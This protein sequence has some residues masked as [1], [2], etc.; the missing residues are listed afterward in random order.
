MERVHYRR[1][2]P[3]VESAPFLQEEEPGAL[4]ETLILQGIISGVM[5]VV[6]ML[7]SVIN[8]AFLSPAQEAI[9]ETL[10]GATNLRELYEATR[11]FGAETLG[12]SWLE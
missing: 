2:R 4:G 1:V 12:L 11:Y 6:V 8:F 5:L 10:Q 3:Q 7:I 9:A